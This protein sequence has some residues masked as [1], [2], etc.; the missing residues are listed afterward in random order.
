MS[1]LSTHLNKD[2]HWEYGTNIAGG[3]WRLRQTLKESGESSPRLHT[4]K[5]GT[6]IGD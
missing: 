6:A 3:V 2:T 5:H 1:A 4:P